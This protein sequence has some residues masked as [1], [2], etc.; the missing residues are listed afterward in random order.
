MSAFCNNNWYTTTKYDDH[1]M[2]VMEPKLHAC[3]SDYVTTWFEAETQRL[4]LYQTYLGTIFICLVL[5]RSCSRVKVDAFRLIFIYCAGTLP[6][7]L[8]VVYGPPHVGF[9]RYLAFG[10]LTHNLPEWFIISRIWIG[11]KFMSALIAIL[12]VCTFTIFIIFIPLPYLFFIGMIQGAFVDYSLVL[13]FI[14]LL[15]F[16]N[17]KTTINK[18]GKHIIKYIKIGLS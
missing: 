12:Y 8:A 10:I 7:V 3:P 4:A 16:F 1:W 13:S 2:S 17:K 18:Y 11:N 6:V 15:K 9:H 14:Y 5:W